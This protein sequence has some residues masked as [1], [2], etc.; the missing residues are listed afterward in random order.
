MPF[1]ITEKGLGAKVWGLKG[2]VGN[3]Q[4]APRKSKHVVSRSY[5]FLLVCHI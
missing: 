5:K 3:L 4:V 2:K 1:W